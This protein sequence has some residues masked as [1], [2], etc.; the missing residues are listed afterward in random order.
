M[1]I[2]NQFSRTVQSSNYNSSGKLEMSTVSSQV[3]FADKLQSALTEDSNYTGPTDS[4]GIVIRQMNIRGDKS[5]EFEH[6]GVPVSIGMDDIRGTQITIGESDPNGNW[7]AIS[8]KDGVVNINL[9]DTQ[10]IMKCLDLFSPEVIKQIMMALAQENKVEE[11][12]KELEDA[13]DETMDATT[14]ETMET[15]QNSSILTDSSAGNE[16]QKD[17]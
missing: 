13:I 17:M 9:D 14:D 3:P 8:T 12:E 1:L 6:N 7:I 15:I 11:A 10:S 2:S 5:R 16:R 4:I